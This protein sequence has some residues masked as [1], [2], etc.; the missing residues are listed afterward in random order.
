MAAHLILSV[1]VRP[2]HLFCSLCLASTTARLHELPNVRLSLF[3]LVQTR[4][5]RQRS[6]EIGPT[7][8]PVLSWLFFFGPYATE[9]APAALPPQATSFPPAAAPAN[10]ATSTNGPRQPRCVGIFRT[11]T[12]VAC[13]RSDVVTNP[14]GYAASYAAG[15]AQ[16]SFVFRIAVLPHGKFRPRPFRRTATRSSCSSAVVVSILSL[17]NLKLLLFPKLDLF[18]FFAQVGFIGWASMVR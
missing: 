16:R 18:A 8:L 10:T 3:I 12:V 11:H 13:S 1:W 14:R 7:I 2:R 9:R 5:R 17:L 15:P 4:Q 6:V